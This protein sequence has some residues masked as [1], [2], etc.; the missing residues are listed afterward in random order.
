MATVEIFGIAPSTYTR[1]VLMACQE[2]GVDHTLKVAPPHSPDINAIHPFGKVPAMRHG[3]VELCESKAIA[4]Y[5]DRSF[6]GPKLLPENPID[7][8][9]AEQWISLVSS[10][11]DPV[12]VRTYLFQYVFPKG[13][14]GKPDR[15]AID[16][17]VPKMREHI[18]LLEKAVAKTGHL[19]GE[20]FSFADMNLMPIL[21]YLTQFPESAQAIKDAKHLSAYFERHSARPSF[22]NTVPPMPGQQAA[23]R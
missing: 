16:A 5:L 15:A 19:A 21:A 11:I 8:A 4:S 17:V 10:V 18:T 13:A 2:K 20:S 12:L 9:L 7:A 23:P 22:K 6:P 14:D 3:D 1:A